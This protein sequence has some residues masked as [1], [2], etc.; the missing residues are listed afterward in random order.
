MAI[1]AGCHRAI[2]DEKIPMMNIFTNYSAY[3]VYIGP[4]LCSSASVCTENLISGPMCVKN[5]VNT[6]RA[7][8][9]VFALLSL[10]L[11]HGGAKRHISCA[12]A[13][14]KALVGG[15]RPKEEP[16]GG[17]ITPLRALF[18]GRPE[19]LKGTRIPT[20][21]ALTFFMRLEISDTFDPIYLTFRAISSIFA[22]N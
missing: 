19:R 18:L 21:L 7:F 11:S 20:L 10:C 8:V 2:S 4:A 6:T 12:E 14:R 16:G 5:P 9:T 1:V 3:I 15:S 13:P 17:G 22:S